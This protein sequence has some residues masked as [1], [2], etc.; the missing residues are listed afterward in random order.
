MK[1]GLA[2]AAAV[3]GSIALNYSIYLQ[4]MAVE[5]LP[6]VKFKLSWSVIKAFITDVPWIK[7]QAFNIFGFAIYAVA[8]AFA[9]VSIVEPIIASGVV[10][11]AYLAMKHLGEKPRRMDLYAMGMNVLGVIFIGISLIKGEGTESYPHHPIEIWIFAGIV[12]AIAVFAPLLLRK[13]SE[14]GQAAGLGISVGALFGA[15]AVFTRLLMLNITKGNWLEVGIFIV[16]CIACYLPGFIVLQAALQKG[17]AIVVAPVYNGL[18]ELVPIVIGMI[19]LN[20]SFPKNK[21]GSLNIPLT[22]VRIIAFCLILAGTIILSQR[23]EEAEEE[24]EKK[25][26]AARAGKELQPEPELE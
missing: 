6:E 20:E 23:A 5:T 14:S 15:A 7:A 19:I 16:V 26:I 1:L 11:L 10:L 21:N 17:M 9:P 8:L 24:M 4:K 18:M 2:I 13:G 25:A 12:L 3:L 22:V